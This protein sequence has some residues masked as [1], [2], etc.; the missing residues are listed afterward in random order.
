MPGVADRGA[1]SGGMV[2]APDPRAAHAGALMLRAGG[3]AVDA[4]VATAFAIGVVE[5]FMSGIGGGAWL[6]VREPGARTA[7]T[8]CGPIRAPGLATADMFP[9]APGADAAGLYGW[10]AVRGEANIIGPL[11]VGTPGAVAALCRAHARFGRLPLAEVLAPAIELAEEGHETNWF[12]SSAICAEA[13]ALRAYPDS[14]ALFLPGGLPL[15]GPSQGPGDR[16]VQPRLAATLRDIAEGGP[17]AFYRGR[18]GRAIAAFTGA[19]G[20]ALREEDLAGYEAAEA[21]IE[22]VAIGPLRVYGPLATGVVSVAEALQIVEAAGRAGLDRG[23]RLWARALSRAFDDRLREVGT[24]EEEDPA[25]ARLAGAE[26]A[27]EVVAEWTAGRGTARRPLAGPARAGCTSHLSAVDGRGMTV[28]LTQTVLD[29]FGSRM[30]EP[31][32]GVVLNDGMMYFDPRPGRVTSIA[33][34]AAGLSAVSPV[35]VTGPGG[36][37]VLGAS[38]GRRIISAVAQ[39][40]ARWRDGAT[41]Q[42]AVDAPRLHAEG[43]RVWLDRREERAA[44]DLAAAG[45]DVRVV[46]EEPTTWH[47][48]RPNGIARREG[49]GWTPGVDRMKP[50]GVG[51]CH[52]GTASLPTD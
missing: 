27:E 51:V 30:V 25:W 40:I 32:T 42:D 39:I 41:L 31:E 9:L 10:P 16:L 48:A 13:R 46:A 4:A 37:A 21:E 43:T 26:H 22:P 19:A 8:V 52:D 1:A 3:S 15:R 17:E 34:G 20:G 44:A 28:S 29:L 6:V 14:A 38:G 12:A 35:I 2:T 45:H 23:P 18:A 33:P 24:G 50:H 7:T 49:T 47:F 36:E 5:P 11:S